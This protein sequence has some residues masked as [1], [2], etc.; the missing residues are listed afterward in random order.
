MKETEEKEKK[1]YKHQKAKGKVIQEEG[2][3]QH[4]PMLPR[5][6]MYRVK[7][8]CY[9]YCRWDCDGL[10]DCHFRWVVGTENTMQQVDKQVQSEQEKDRNFEGKGHPSIC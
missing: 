9:I 6:A 3:R 5:Q 2:C 8:F 4:F 10:G 7:S 1:K